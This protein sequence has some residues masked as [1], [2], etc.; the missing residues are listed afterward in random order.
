MRKLEARFWF[1]LEVP[2]NVGVSNWNFQCVPYKVDVLP[3]SKTASHNPNACASTSTLR[4][5][6]LFQA[7][8]CNSHKL[9]VFCRGTPESSSW[10]VETAVSFGRE[11]FSAKTF[12][13]KD[14]PRNRWRA[15]STMKCFPFCGLEVEAPLCGSIVYLVCLTK[16][17]SAG[18]PKRLV[19]EKV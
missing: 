19:V 3:A 11:K 18:A 10:D 6:L 8:N 16:A 5:L 17:V 1:D 15:I 2:F 12:V 9:K 14:T 4:K 13:T 7:F